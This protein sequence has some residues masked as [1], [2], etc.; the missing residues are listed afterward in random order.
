MC[1]TFA[2]LFSLLSGDIRSCCTVDCLATATAAAAAVAAID[3]DC[4]F[5]NE[6]QKHKIGKFDGN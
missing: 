2:A 4:H 5:E 3:C 6:N 1:S